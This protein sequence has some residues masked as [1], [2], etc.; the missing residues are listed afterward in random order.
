MG[1]SGFPVVP[2]IF[3]RLKGGSGLR[4]QKNQPLQCTSRGAALL[5]LRSDYAPESRAPPAAHWT[6]FV[7]GRSTENTK[8]TMFFRS[9]SRIFNT[10]IRG[11]LQMFETNCPGKRRG[12][13]GCIQSNHRG[14]WAWRLKIS[15]RFPSVPDFHADHPSRWKTDGSPGLVPMS[16]GAQRSLP[17]SHLGCSQ[18]RDRNYC[19]NVHSFETWKAAQT[20]RVS[21]FTAPNGPEKPQKGAPNCPKIRPNFCACSWHSTTSAGGRLDTMRAPNDI[22]VLQSLWTRGCLRLAGVWAAA[23]RWQELNWCIHDTTQ[24]G[25]TALRRSMH[26]LYFNIFQILSVCFIT[27]WHEKYPTYPNHQPPLE[28]PHRRRQFHRSSTGDNSTASALLPDAPG[29]RWLGENAPMFGHSQ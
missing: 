22:F 25:T 21:D 24:K 11:V 4:L 15:D 28:G 10:F 7:T 1:C 16:T 8:K 17:C 9:K 18:G 3:T 6:G 19:G 20:M 14:R 29:M 13:T 27:P 12:M 23:F 26:T 5:L 2:Q